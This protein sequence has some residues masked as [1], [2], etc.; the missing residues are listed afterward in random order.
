MWKAD[1]MRRPVIAIDGPAGSGKSTLARALALELEVPYVNTG[2]MYR[3]LAAR[4]LE[5]GV[6]PD[7]G[8]ALR[9]L[10]GPMRFALAGGPPASL[11]IDGREPGPELTAPPVEAA[12][13]RVARHPAVRAAMRDLQRSLGA[14]GGAIE[15]RDIGTV[16]F[17]DADVKLFL[18]A[19]EAERAERRR[20]ERGGA[21]TV[22]EALAAR[23]RQDARVNPF[24]P[25]ADAIAIDTSALDAEATLERAL[26]IVRE[27]RGGAA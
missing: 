19:E 6:D 1:G 13:S 10:L 11:R 23:D 8:D 3:A 21:E 15:G 4:A 7:D 24:V 27:R 17:P 14:D 16:V 2:L 26:A 25:A 18:S 5:V 9:A 20:R 22:S 12:V